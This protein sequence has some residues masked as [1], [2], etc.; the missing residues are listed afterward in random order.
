MRRFTVRQRPLQP[1]KR[2]HVIHL[3]ADG[4]FTSDNG[5]R[6]AANLYDLDDCVSLCF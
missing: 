1:T 5:D 6:V 3:S 2:I 4:S